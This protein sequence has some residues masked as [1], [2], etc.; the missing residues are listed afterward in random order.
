M[1]YIIFS[2]AFI[3][4]MFVAL[5]ADAA[6]SDPTPLP[7]DTP[8]FISGVKFED[9]NA[10]GVRDVDPETLEYIEPVIVGWK[11]RIKDLDSNEV[12][13]TFTDEFG[14]YL[15]EDLVPSTYR[16]TEKQKNGWT[17]TAPTENNGKYTV[18]LEENEAYTGLDFGNFQNAKISGTK[19]EDVNGNGL[20]DDGEI[21]LPGWEIILEGPSGTVSTNTDDLGNY[22]FT[23]LPPGDY[24]V[25]ETMQPGWGQSQ[26]GLQEEFMYS[27]T[28]E[29]GNEYINTNFGN[30]KFITIKGR[31]YKD[32][33]FNGER[34]RRE[35]YLRG[36]EI[37]LYNLQTGEVLTTTTNRRGRYSFTELAPGNYIV[38]EILQSGW[39]PVNPSSTIHRVTV[40]SNQVLSGI[41][42]GNNTIE[43][44]IK[45]NF[46]V[47]PFSLPPF[48][49]DRDPEPIAEPIGEPV[50]EELPTT[51]TPEYTTPIE[52]VVTNIKKEVAEKVDEILETV[53]DVTKTARRATAR[54][55]R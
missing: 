21:G 31:K 27:I 22:S 2:F 45:Y 20:L 38:R 4:A 46:P 9:I 28:P 35:P 12:T 40:V 6:I 50:V 37:V 5:P 15:F 32:L 25:T 26:P 41:N 30:Y 44:F 47:I 10:N 14:V 19:Y 51:P 8:S 54:F 1:K 53:E 33:N 23:D 11:I 42:F 17:Q 55:R 13:T 29:S 43:N 49:L 7:T 3:A 16:V 24:V 36:W 34:N 18:V 52:R 39:Y 48:I